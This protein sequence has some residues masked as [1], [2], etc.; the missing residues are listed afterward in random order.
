MIQLLQ[1]T[2]KEYIRFI[3]S[4]NGCSNNSPNINIELYDLPKNLCTS[5]RQL[6]FLFWRNGLLQAHSDSSYQYQWFKNDT[7]LV[8]ADSSSLQV[9]AA[10]S[11]M[12]KVQNATCTVY[13]TVQV[14]F[15]SNPTPVIAGDSNLVLC[16][17][18]LIS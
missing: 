5:K 12:I 9:D 15:N 11:Y 6:G 14:V 16:A 1:L 10:G 13:D 18:H 17:V 4:A 3:T 2:L 7:L 8:G